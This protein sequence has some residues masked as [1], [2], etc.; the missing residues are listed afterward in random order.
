MNENHNLKK[1]DVEYQRI[2]KWLRITFGK[3]NK[4]EMK[5]CKIIE[6]K[7]YEYALIRGKKYERKR[8]NFMM[9]CKSCHVKYD[10][11]ETTR[12]KMRDYRIGKKQSKNTVKK[13]SLSILSSGK[14]LKNVDKFS[15]L[16]VY[17][18]SYTGIEK[19]ALINNCSKT[20]ISNA[21]HGRSR[22]SGGYIWKL[23]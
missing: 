13:R 19:A 18:E 23:Q 21:L 14:L 20:S 9:L 10:F 2:H 22:T 3:A 6:A 7:R 17:I 4:C 16:G 11:T 5:M 15:S 12:K 1:Y 8:E